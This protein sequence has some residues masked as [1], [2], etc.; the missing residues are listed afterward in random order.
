ME[1]DLD[2]PINIRRN[3]QSQIDSFRKVH[4]DFDARIVFDKKGDKYV[5]KALITGA[6]VSYEV[7]SVDWDIRQA[8]ERSLMDLKQKL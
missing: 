8:F 1:T 5:C 6:D 2:L 4:E 3:L 7:E